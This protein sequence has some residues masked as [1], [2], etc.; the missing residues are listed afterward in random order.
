MDSIWVLSLW[1]D[2]LHERERISAK[3]HD[4]TKTA[5]FRPCC[6]FKTQ[7]L[8]M[9]S[10][11]T[12]KSHTYNGTNR[13]TLLSVIWS[14]YALC[15]HAMSTWIVL[16]FGLARFYLG[17]WFQ[18]PTAL[19][20]RGWVSERLSSASS[21]LLL[22]IIAS[23]IIE[24]SCEKLHHQ[25]SEVNIVNGFC[26]IKPFYLILFFIQTRELTSAI[27]SS[28]FPRVFPRGISLLTFYWKM[29]NVDPP[30]P[31]QRVKEV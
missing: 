27:C 14:F 10:I 18:M 15:D 1:V 30:L 17:S 12:F 26:N 9:M 7:A 5:S 13:L 16:R 24:T 21:L 22:K 19:R 8:K 20:E 6:A 28:E 11:K 2:K 29:K 4:C 31:N 25:T 3:L 23:I